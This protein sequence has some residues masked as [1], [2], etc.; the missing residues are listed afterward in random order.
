MI[1]LTPLLKKMSK[2][3]LYVQLYQYIKEEIEKGA[4]YSGTLLPSIRQLSQHLEVS[5]N[6]VEGAYQQLLAEGYVESI[7]RVG[8]RV[9]SLED[10]LASYRQIESD[11]TA[12][13]QAASNEGYNN[14]ETNELSIRYDF[15]YGDVDV[16]HFPMKLW[17]K[18]LQK[19]LTV[20]NSK[21]LMYGDPFGDRGLREELSQYLLQARGFTCSSEQIVIC[22]GTQHA[23]S[24]LS[25]L[26]SLQGSLVA[27]E[28]PGYDGVRSVFINQACKVIPVPLEADGI[29]VSDLQASNAKAVYLT[30]SHQLPNGMIM[31]IQ[32]RLMLLHWAYEHHT[33]IIEDD[34]DSEFRYQGQPVP[35]LKALDKRE[36]VIYL[37]TFSKCFLPSIRVSYLVLPPMLVQLYKLR[38]YNYN[39]ASSPIIQRALYLFMRNG[40]FERHIRRMRK[41]YHLKHKTLL[42]AID[43][44]LGD[45][46]EVIGEKSGLHILLKVPGQMDHELI[47]KALNYGVQVYSTSKFWYNKQQ[48]DPSTLMLGFGSLSVEEIEDGIRLLREAIR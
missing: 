37:G 40:D 19:A 44:Y 47:K 45:K 15:I 48:H 1:A 18:Y 27:I 13:K 14:T 32:K 7:P 10:T 41:I 36:S 24:I 9:L 16:E 12:A 20:E 42:N 26:L 35:A 8:L 17:N 3:P 33:Y 28:E 5:K 43:R 29:S 38:L 21:L 4:I 31:P 11:H 2:K 23:I 25:Q 6:T 34:Y 39:Q 22:S 46:V 30:P